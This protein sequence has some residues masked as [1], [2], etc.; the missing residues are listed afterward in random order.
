MVVCPLSTKFLKPIK[1]D[2]WNFLWIIIK[3][4]GLVCKVIFKE[5][6][7]RFFY[8]K[9]FRIHTMEFTY[10][11]KLY[12]WYCKGFPKHVFVFLSTKDTVSKSIL[13]CFWRTEPK[14][15]QVVSSNRFHLTTNFV[16]TECLKISLKG[17]SLPMTKWITAPCLV[18]NWIVLFYLK[19][20]E[21]ILLGWK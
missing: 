11:H 5:N 16:C 1:M 3:V 2:K 19:N 14:E 10:A 7:K 8:Q 20:F 18:G 21:S 4:K 13:N 15:M 6:V 17:K 9:A 12:C